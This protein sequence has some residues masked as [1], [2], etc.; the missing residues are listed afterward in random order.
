MRQF[1]TDH[2]EKSFSVEDGTDEFIKLYSNDG[3]YDVRKITTSTPTAI[4]VLVEALPTGFWV[5][6]QLSVSAQSPERIRNFT[7]HHIE[8]PTELLPHQ[9]LT[10]SQIREKAD[11]LI[12]RLV[13]ADQFSGAILVARDGKPIYER[14]C[15]MASRAWSAPNRLDPRFNIASLE[16]MITAVAVAQ[17]VEYGKLSF[18]DTVGKIL[19]GFPVRDVARKV[20]VRHLLTHTSGIKPGLFTMGSGYRTLNEYRPVNS[21]E[22]LL[23]EP[24][25]RYDY[26]NDGYLLLGLIIEK[27]SGQNYYD[28]V[29]DHIFKPAGMAN[30]DNY[31]LDSDPPN[32]AT[33]YMDGPNGTRRG[34]IFMLPVKGRPE[35]FGYSTVGDMARFADALRTHVL[36]S[37]R[38]L[39][40]V[41]TGS[42]DEGS[43]A[44]RYGYGFEIK[45]YNG[46]RIIGHGGGWVG[47]TNQ[48]DMYPDLGYTVVILTNIDDSPR[49][50]AYELREWLTQGTQSMGMV[51]R[52]V[53]SH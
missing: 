42:V 17:L 31:E 46:T 25:S 12:T 6:V 26:S 18:G 40:T 23:F 43:G 3:R 21:S 50:I 44:T 53:P 14:A 35:G 41:W 39:D 28:Y 48:M 49:S 27:A 5:E 1:L 15:G 19:S 4:T 10:D 2:A 37:A 16:K 30:T 9:R 32:I 52:N 22:P 33:G 7:Y 20:T 8:A 34:N 29:R 11:A 47:V 13:A 38:S 45:R 51:R 36:L 24:G